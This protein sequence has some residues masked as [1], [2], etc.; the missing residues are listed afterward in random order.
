MSVPLHATQLG[1]INTHAPTSHVFYHEEGALLLATR[2]P[3]EAAG[4]F[5]AGDSS[6]FSPRTRML[7]SSR[8]LTSS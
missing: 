4:F 6:S 2:T 5:W 8:N 7:C 3:P 1:D